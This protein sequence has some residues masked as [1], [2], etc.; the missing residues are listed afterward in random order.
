MAGRDG[1]FG[2]LAAAHYEDWYET[3]EGQR[4]DALEKAALW[5]LL[6]GFA[7]AR[8]ILEVGCG[9]GHFTRWLGDQGL[10]AVGLDVSAAMLAQAQ[11]LNRASLVRGD[12]SRLPFADGAFDLTALVT[13]LEFL[14]WPKDALAEAVRVGRRGVVLG[15]LNR[16]SALGLW[17]RL[18]ALFRPTVYGMARFYS[19]REAKRLLRSVADGRGRIEWRSTLFPRW[20]PW[21][22]ADLPWGGFVAM[23]LLLPGDGLTS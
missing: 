4:A 18:V 23:A 16:R 1:V 3:S 19:V 6:E 21:P 14:E 12:A 7:G 22:R 9:T 13:T 10:A 11:A 17:R 2:E 5:R 15:L 8:S 20:W